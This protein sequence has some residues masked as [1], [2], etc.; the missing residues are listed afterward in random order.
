M[1]FRSGDRLLAFSA[2]RAPRGQSPISCAKRLRPIRGQ[3]ISACDALPA[4][5]GPLPSQSEL[6]STA[7]KLWDDVVSSNRH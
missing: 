7:G 4:G 6:W 3:S 2:H 1:L 5:G